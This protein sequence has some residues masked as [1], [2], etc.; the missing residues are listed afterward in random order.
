MDK[1][2]KESSDVEI[3][4]IGKNREGPEYMVFLR[5]RKRRMGFQ[6]RVG[7]QCPLGK[8]GSRVCCHDTESDHAGPRTAGPASARLP[9]GSS[10]SQIGPEEEWIVVERWNILQ[11]CG[12]S[13]RSTLPITATCLT[14]E[15]YMS[16][17]LAHEH[18]EHRRSIATNTDHIRYPHSLPPETGTMA[19]VMN[20]ASSLQRKT[21]TEAISS[22]LGQ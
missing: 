10:V 2:T 18:F 11:F 17:R 16:A 12:D 8:R 4:A 3:L 1:I 13:D 21:A 22:G 15:R 5:N 6:H 14:I 9:G 19:P 20:F 7:C